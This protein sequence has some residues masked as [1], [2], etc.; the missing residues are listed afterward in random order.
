MV[1]GEQIKEIKVGKKP[2]SYCMEMGNVNHS[3]NKMKWKWK[4][5]KECTR[6]GL[7]FSLFPPSTH[8]AAHAVNNEQWGR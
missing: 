5:R 7:C 3:N 4:A 8:R 2:E 6:R 1:T